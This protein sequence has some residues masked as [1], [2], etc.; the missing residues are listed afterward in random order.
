MTSAHDRTTQSLPRRS[1][2]KVE[3]TW[4][5]ESMFRTDE[6]WHAAYHHVEGRLP[7][8]EAYRGRT[9]E[10]AATLLTAL[11]LRDELR[12]AV[13]KVD[14]YAYLRR[15]ED[16]TNPDSAALA[17]RAS[18]LDSALESAA[19]FIE[20]EILRLSGETIRQFVES[21]PRLAI[22]QHYLEKLG[23]M[24]A[25][26]RSA[27]V[28][29]LLAQANNVMGGFAG[30]RGA[31]ENADLHLGRIQDHDGNTVELSQGNYLQYLRDTNRD[32]R[33]NTWI[34]TSDAYLSK[35]NTFAGTLAGGVKRDVFNMRA[36]NFSSSLEASLFPNAIPIEVFH[37]LI[38]TVWNNLP[39][40]HRYFEIR[41][42][43]LGLDT[44][45]EWDITAP[46]TTDGPDLSF[47]DGMTIILDS[48]VPLGA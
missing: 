47:D 14:V 28:E 15:A 19:S 8:L 48:L 38:D 5:L 24:Q 22:F 13:D 37:N 34:S 39:T 45:H 27:E 42:R 2:L 6:E 12:K 1:N 30:V 10:S 11:Q 7:E 44:Q 18:N 33:R 36:R 20:P 26:V 29:E 3:D 17:E 31:L 9:G 41:K 25:H 16:A 4:N 40:W 43:I 32:V 21:E 35:K 23:R 46:L